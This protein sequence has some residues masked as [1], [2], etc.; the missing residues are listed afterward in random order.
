MNVVAHNMLA[1][2]AARQFN[3]NSKETK[4]SQEKL[5][6]GYRINRAGDDAAGLAISEKMKHQ[7]RGLNRGSRNCQEGVSY[8]Q[9]ADGALS[10]TMEVMRRIS[11]L[12]VQAANGT[13]SYQDRQDIQ[14][15][16]NQILAEN[17]RVFEET[18]F[19]GRKIFRPDRNDHV[20][21]IIS[22][23]TGIETASPLKSMSAS[24]SASDRSVFSYTFSADEASGITINGETHP[25]DEMTLPEGSSLSALIDGVYSIDHDGVGIS[26]LIEGAGDLAALAESFNGIT[27]Q[28]TEETISTI[29]PG[30]ESTPVTNPSVSVRASEVTD[31]SSLTG[32]HSLSADA[33]GLSMDGGTRH[34]WDE[35]GLDSSV[36]SAGGS[37]TADLGNGIGFSFSVTAGSELDKV[38]GALNGSAFEIASAGGTS[39]TTTSDLFA[40]DPFSIDIKWNNKDN[41]LEDDG[42]IAAGV[43]ASPAS[44]DFRVEFNND[45]GTYFGSLYNNGARTPYVLDTDSKEALAQLI[46]DGTGIST[47][48]TVAGIRFTRGNSAFEMDFVAKSDFNSNSLKTGIQN[49]AGHISLTKSWTANTPSLTPVYEDV[50]STTTVDKYSVSGIKASEKEYANEIVSSAPQN[51]RYELRIQA[52]SSANDYLTLNIDTISNHSLGLDG[53]DV[54]SDEG[55]LDAIDRSGKA[56]E[57]LGEIR[58]RL[59]AQQNRLEHTIDQINNTSENTEASLSR[60]SDTDI[61][62]EMVRYV[63]SNLLE[64]VGQSMMAQANQNT[65]SVLSILGG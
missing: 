39:L 33:T 10:E 9:V 40:R 53:I 5:S 28:R 14:H 27:L 36:L 50:I 54:R 58:A 44:L 49:A 64:Q 38:A 55:A 29:V 3:I 17:E 56:L 8:L 18:S 63:K 47:G 4:K 34:T 61:P 13:N 57:E 19:N 25:W 31:E 41:P 52:S 26:F 6:S 46:S 45:T 32:S 60:I 16:I 20:S 35:L 51:R 21:E 23:D 43:T 7:I 65:N 48:E 15:E 62:E 59:G 1:E 24:G 37:I 2:F 12:S 11:E 22:K 42:V 30:D